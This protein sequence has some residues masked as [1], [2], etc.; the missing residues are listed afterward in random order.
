V[1]GPSEKISVAKVKAAIAKMK[2]NKAAD[3][4]GVASEMLKLSGRP[5]QIGWLTCSMKLWFWQ[6]RV[7]VGKPVRTRA[8]KLL[9]N[10]ACTAA[11]ICWNTH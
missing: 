10:V 4:S 7:R 6:T 11:L 5:V 9:G 1:S 2:N 3:L 8:R